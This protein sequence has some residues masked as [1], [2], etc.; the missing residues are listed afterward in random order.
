MVK[1]MRADYEDKH[2]E[3]NQGIGSKCDAMM[4]Q[5]EQINGQLSTIIQ[6]YN[7]EIDEENDNN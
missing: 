7:Q 2:E 3:I 6:M 1:N 5:T 4:S